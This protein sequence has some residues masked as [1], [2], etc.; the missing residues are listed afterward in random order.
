MSERAWY[1]TFRSMFKGLDRCVFLNSAGVAMVSE[2]VRDAVL[3]WAALGQCAEFDYYAI[4]SEAREN[5]AAMVSGRTDRIFFS[6]NTTH[7]I[8]TFILGYPWQK[9]DGVIVADCEFPANRLSWLGLRE[10]KGVGVRIVKSQNSKAAL[11]D[12]YKLCDK[13]TKVIAI[14]WVQYLSGQKADLAALGRFCRAHDI[15]LVVDGIQGIGA[16]EMNAE[17]L[18]IDWLSADGHKWMCGPEGVG[19]VWMSERAFNVVTP[20]CKGWFGVEQPFNFEEFDQDYEANANRFLDG[21]PMV[22]GIMAFSAALKMLL[23]FGMDKIAARVLELSAYTINEAKRR[24]WEVLTPLNPEDRA[25]IA[26]FRPSSGD[27]EVI[28]KKLHD[29]NII[30][31][32]RGG[33]WLR[34]SAHAFNNHEDIDKAFYVIDKNV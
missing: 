10:K 15:L 6:R 11:D 2:P 27:L 7:G 22:L 20:A 28:A 17:E 4:V 21:S 3:R 34:L 26:T 24:G 16:A 12:Y 5:A 23:S 8:H 14:S 29:N 32:L 13:D 33:G 1:E 9:G 19:L 31:S 18:N 25:G 30:C